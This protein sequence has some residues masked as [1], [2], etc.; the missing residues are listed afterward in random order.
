[1]ACPHLLG[2]IYTRFSETPATRQKRRWQIPRA[3]SVTHP[4]LQFFG[5]TLSTRHSMIID[6]DKKARRC[7]MSTHN[8]TTGIETISGGTRGYYVV[9]RAPAADRPAIRPK[10]APAINPAPPG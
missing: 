7:I 6:V 8:P 10:T 5:G 4:G 2:Q 1:M 9:D 3:R